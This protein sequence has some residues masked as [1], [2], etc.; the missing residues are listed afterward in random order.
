M[1]TSPP[2][3]GSFQTRETGEAKRGEDL[4]GI[5]E[6]WLEECSDARYSPSASSVSIRLGSQFI[7]YISS[8]V[9]LT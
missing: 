9:L 1:A 8:P 3:G 2:F 7:H 5:L 4:C 6:G